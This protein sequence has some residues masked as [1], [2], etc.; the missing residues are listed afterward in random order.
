MV[1]S[2]FIIR[3]TQDVELIQVLIAFQSIFE[4]RNGSAHYIMTHIHLGIK[5][6]SIRITNMPK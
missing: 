5:N 3:K 1:T 2:W 6:G 4:I